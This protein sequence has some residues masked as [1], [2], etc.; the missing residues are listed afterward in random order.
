MELLTLEE[1]HGLCRLCLGENCILK[2]LFEPVHPINEKPTANLREKILVSTSIQVEEADN[3]PTKICSECSVQVE[4]L[5]EFKQKCLA[6]DALL[7]KHVRLKF[8]KEPD[9]PVQSSECSSAPTKDATSNGPVMVALKTDTP[10][11]SLFIYESEML[12]VEIKEEEEDIF[13]K[14]SGDETGSEVKE[15]GAP[16]KRKPILKSKTPFKDTKFTC[17]LCRKSFCNKFSLTRHKWS[18]SKKTTTC[19]YCNKIF[20][21]RESQQRHEKM[22]EI[23]NRYQCHL[24]DKSYVSSTSHAAHVRK[25][26]GERPYKCSDCNA[27][28]YLLSSFERHVVKHSGVKEYECEICTASFWV[29]DDLRAHVNRMH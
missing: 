19:K 8:G 16:Q 29:P 24:C 7:R 21:N 18:H 1:T 20:K 17:Q 22:H 25:H 14:S 10:Q 6:A 3:L 26:T 11:S 9:R 27:S 12:N 4:K 28:F 13:D 2:D 23:G 15:Q 5:Y